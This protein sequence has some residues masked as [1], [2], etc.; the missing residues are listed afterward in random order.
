M[1]PAVQVQI[2]KCQEQ[3]NG[4][5]SS[6]SSL[7]NLKCTS[8]MLHHSCAPEL[9]DDCNPGRQSCFWLETTDWWYDDLI[10]F[11]KKPRNG[12]LCTACD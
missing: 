9:Y 1:F 8:V 5:R 12:H 2:T 6:A 10:S 3:T 7:Y 11:F 4:P